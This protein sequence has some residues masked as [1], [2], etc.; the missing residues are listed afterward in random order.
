MH[1]LW[2]MRSNSSL[3]LLLGLLGARDGAPERILSTV[4]IKLNSIITLTEFFDNKN[5]YI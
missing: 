5:Y 3:P 4:Q 2:G 1:E